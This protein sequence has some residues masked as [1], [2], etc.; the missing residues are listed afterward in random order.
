MAKKPKPIVFDI[1]DAINTEFPDIRV[2]MGS[3]EHKM[4]EATVDT[5]IKNVRDMDLLQKAENL[6]EELEI[7][8]RII[9]RA[10]PTMK[11]EDLTR[12]SLKQLNELANF[13]RRANDEIT[14]EDLE[15]EA[16]EPGKPSAEE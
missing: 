8:M 3:V 9:M 7:L 5:F 12:L 4:Q 2:K 16:A 1:D 11:R 15:R 10:F 6:L 13:G 14:D